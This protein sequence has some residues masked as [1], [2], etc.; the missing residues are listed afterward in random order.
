MYLLGV[1]YEND[2]KRRFSGYYSVWVELWVF[3]YVCVRMYFIFV[4]WEFMKNNFEGI[5]INFIILW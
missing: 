4:Y 2:C 1:F 3:V 5:F